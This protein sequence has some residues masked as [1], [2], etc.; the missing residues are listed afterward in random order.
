MSETA[1]GMCHLDAGM[2]EQGLKEFDSEKYDFVVLENV[3]WETE[4]RRGKD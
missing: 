4:K 3:G 2:T 1:V